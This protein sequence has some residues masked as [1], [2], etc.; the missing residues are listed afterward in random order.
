MILFLIFVLGARLFY[1]QILLG[2]NYSALAQKQYRKKVTTE[3]F[4]GEILDRNGIVLAKT[5]ES[6][7][8]FL[9]PK[10]LKK[11]KKSAERLRTT[12]FGNLLRINTKKDFVWLERK[13]NS[14]QTEPILEKKIPGVGVV[15][16]QKRYYPNGS[17]ACH[18]L[19]TVG[20][21]NHGLAGIEQSL[22]SFLTGKH[23]T[24]DQLRDA[25]G[26]NILK[27]PQ[28][29]DL[30]E[31][32]ETPGS[33]SIV[34]TIDRAIQYIAERELRRG[35]EEYGAARGIVLV[36]QPQTGEILAMAS[37][38]GF[39]PN[40]ISSGGDA[41]EIGNTQ[42]QNSIVSNAFEPGSTFKIV[43]FAAALEEK[44][45]SLQDSVD[46]EGGQW[47][48]GT[49]TI[50]D[51][52]PSEVLT[53]S[54]VLEKSSNIGTAKIGLKLGRETLYKYIRAFGFGTK[55]GI[56]LPGES[57]GLLKMPDKW[58]GSSQPTIA[59][60]Q[61][62]G[63]TAI[64]LINAFSAIA[65]DGVLME[66]L[67]LKELVETKG[68]NLQRNSFPPQIVRQ[69]VSPE[70]ARTLRQMLTQAVE[71]GTGTRAKI[72]G[73][74]VAGK[75]GTAQKIDPATRKYAADKHIA[76]FCGFLPADKPQLTCLVVLDEPKK[77]YWGGSTAAPIFSRI[78]AQVA[79]KC[80]IQKTKQNSLTL[81]GLAHP[82]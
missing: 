78:A 62:I 40:Q 15:S 20:M 52:E 28:E 13:L 36:Q 12:P 63:V 70:T 44:T 46:C 73:Y 2:V 71:Q 49:V 39:D 33:N 59:F 3:T 29:S 61:E 42:L 72:E 77:D 82:Q 50:R 1:V 38:P 47:K 5:V 64:Q 60:G 45:G 21:D 22:N 24:M 34:L 66:P 76:S 14:S 26:R 10:E 30:S 80:G 37:Y 58:S 57:E 55:T 18:L 75:T 23:S 41:S 11:N 6:F 19:G 9:R 79:H 31:T 53:F 74:S 69:V 68:T 56:S 25:K 4:R 17:L 54:Q 35:V 16:E 8:V 51:H 81:A 43:A 67:L 65:N 48:L 32:A 27:N 7:S